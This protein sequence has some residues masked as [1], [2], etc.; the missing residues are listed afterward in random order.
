MAEKI[1]PCPQMP[2]EV[3]LD[4][5]LKREIDEKEKQKRIESAKG[6]GVIRES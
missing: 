5:R 6:Q 1:Q 3:R 2:S 4:E